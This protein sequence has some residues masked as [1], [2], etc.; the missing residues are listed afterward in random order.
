MFPSLKLAQSVGP[1]SWLRAAAVPIAVDGG[2]LYGCGADYRAPVQKEL[3]VTATELANRQDESDTSRKRLVDLSRD[4]K[5]NTPEDVR[6]IVA[7]I[8][9]NFQAE[10]DNLSKRSKAAEAA[11]LAVYKKLIEVPD[12]VPSLEHCLSIQ[13]RAMRTQDLEIENRQLR[14]TLKDYN[15]EFKEVKN[16]EVT[17]KQLKEQLKQHEDKL[18]NTL[19]VRAKE[20]EKELQR[21]LSERERQL[22]ENQS[23][24]SQKVK[25]A[26]KKIAELQ[27]AL[28]RSQ[29]ELFDLKS[30]YEEDS[31]AKSDEMEIII[32][33][34][35][36]A[37]QRAAL[38]GKEASQLKEQLAAA[39]HSLQLADQIQKA[40]DMEQA[41]DIVTRSSLEVELAAKDKE[42]SQLVDDIQRLQSSLNNLKETTTTKIAHLEEMVTEKDKIIEEMESKLLRQN[43]YD[44][45]KRELSILKSMEFGTSQTWGNSSPDDQGGNNLSG[46]TKSTKP[47]EVLLLEKTKSLQSENTAL[48]INN[49]DSAGTPLSV[50]NA[51][52]PPLQNVEAFSS[53]L[54]EEIVS[55]YAKTV[56]KEE[57]NSCPAT[58]KSCEDTRSSGTELSTTSIKPPVESSPSAKD[59]PNEVTSLEKLQECLKQNID[60]YANETLNTLSISRCVRELLSVHNIG[61]RLF[62]K[63]ILGLSQGTVSELLSKPKPW[64]KLTEK[65]RDSYRKMHAWASDETCIYML[66]TLIP[67]KDVSKV[68]RNGSVELRNIFKIFCKQHSDEIPS[69]KDIPIWKGKESGVSSY[70]QEDAAAEERIAQILN[71]AQMAMNNKSSK[72]PLHNGIVSCNVDIKPG[73][74]KN[75]DDCRGEGG[76]SGTEGGGGRRTPYNNH[77]YI[78]NNHNFKDCSSR[79]SRKYENDDIPQEMVARIYQEELAKLM[80]QRVEE[81]FRQSRDQYERT[82]DEIR[83]A[84]SIYHQELS[85]LTQLGSVTSAN[86]YSS[87]REDGP[88]DA[89]VQS[90]NRQEQKN[91]GSVDSDNLRHHGSAFSLVRPKA[92]PSTGSVKSFVRNSTPSPTP[93]LLPLSESPA[94]GEDLTSSASPLQRMQSITN[95]LLSQSS[96]PNLPTPPQRPAKAV[97]PPITQQQFDQYNNLNT[98]DIVKKVKEQLS[99]YSISQR[100]FGENVLGL[101]QGSVSDLLARPKPWHMLT[102][103]GREPFIRM[104]IF[105]EDDNAVHK[106]VASQYKIAPE[107]LMRTGGYGGTTTSPGTSKLVPPTSEGNLL[108]QRISESRHSLSSNSTF[109]PHSESALSSISDVPA[110]PLITNNNSSNNASTSSNGNNARRGHSPRNS[111]YVQPSVYEMAALTTDLD[112]QAIT[113]RIKETLMAHNIGQKIFGEAVLGLSQ[114]S[115]SELLSKPKP[116]HML[117]IKGREPFIRMQLWLSDAHNV[118]KLQAI[119]NER[120]EANKRRRNNDSQDSPQLQHEKHVFNFSFAPPSPYPPVKKPRVLFSEEQKEA[121]RLAFSLDS[122]PSTSTI[123]FLGSELNL[124]VR[125]I[126]NWFHNHRMR[127]KQYNSN[128]DD[129]KS[130]ET[131]NNSSLSGVRESASFDPVQFRILLNQRLADLSRERGEHY[132]PTL[133]G[134]SLVYTS[135]RNGSPLSLHG[136]D[137]GTL[138]LSMSS[139]HHSNSSTTVFHVKTEPN[140][141]TDERSNSE[142]NDDS[143]L[144]Q[145]QTIT[146]GSDH[147][148]LDEQSRTQSPHLPVSTRLTVS[149]NSSN[150]RKPAMPQWVDPGLELS[151]NSDVRSDD[152]DGPLEQDKIINGV[153]VRQTV[154][155][156]LPIPQEETVHIEPTPAPDDN[157]NKILDNSS[158]DLNG[159]S[160]SR[161]RSIDDLDKEESRKGNDEERQNNI[162]RMERSLSEQDESWDMVETD[163]E[164]Q[165]NIDKL[166]QRIEQT[167]EDDDWEF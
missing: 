122:Y 90:R 57:C 82:Q 108:T 60:K 68:K 48:K 11:F 9:K 140:S 83:Q 97:L 31:H 143:N 56:A 144:S 25:E 44:E 142:M 135:H 6:K 32:N 50:G 55:R 49:A 1:V 160:L 92:E 7:P 51:F 88:I 131:G 154:G 150:R 110:L 134:M 75:G 98:E 132:N 81:G 58:P 71:E 95:S 37:N 85:R 22:N 62:A 28:E 148:S 19:Q 100:L 41:V 147:E 13:Q 126:T 78:H 5:R 66:K 165:T 18:E 162:K 72:S 115:V 164:R 155:F 138:D 149:G 146:E 127:I 111:S 63:F 43:D 105:L 74:E 112:T 59:S 12:P 91:A 166:Q 65:G 4:F 38:A 8:L 20:K 123:E 61:Q 76:G 47:L 40:P 15:Q 107:K 161:D 77:N 151:P 139:Q 52:P 93:P 129:S 99:Q 102:Q 113:S 128:S 14:E 46:E 109:I 145:D 116:W 96:V 45:I 33:D 152:E 86:S 36:R 54:G 141:S 104:K 163:D 67:R 70:K 119:K 103:K 133:S 53:L 29:S 39:K 16:Q 114:G 26:E 136:D 42:I 10:V 64:D 120:R 27:S 158:K 80:G 130:G 157:M 73:S 24:L 23:I 124:S 30:K 153:C 118:E 156:D 79:R 94:G 84:L 125:T 17:I 167:E 101:S 117:S 137:G 21:L 121:L 87:T 159:N 34:L 2:C 3:D 106:L 35:E 89:T 69:L